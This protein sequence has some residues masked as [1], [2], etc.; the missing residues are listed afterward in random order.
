[1]NSVLVKL[2]FLGGPLFLAMLGA[3]TVHAQ[4][5]EVT[6]NSLLKLK[7][8]AALV[9]QLESNR[10]EERQTASATLA[11][12]GVAAIPVL[13]ERMLV[14]PPETAACC[15]R[16]LSR[17]AMNS[18]HQ[19]M[20][21]I[22]RVFMLLSKNGMQ[23]LGQESV[24][25]NA[26]WKQGRID[27]TVS[28]LSEVGINAEPV[29]Q[30]FAQAV[31]VF[32]EE[33]ITTETESEP[34][35]TNSKNETSPR[36]SPAPQKTDQ[37]ILQIV[38]QILESSQQENNDR[39]VE[40]MQNARVQK[41]Q[42]QNSTESS[43]RE[44]NP[45]A[46]LVESWDLETSENH[47]SVTIGPEFNGADED[48]KLLRLLPEIAQLTIVGQTIDSSML[49]L[50]TEDTTVQYVSLIEC[51]YNFNEIFELLQKR[52][53]MMVTSAGNQAF[54]GVQLQ[55]QINSEGKSVCQVLE[56]VADSA[57]EEAGIQALDVI[58]S[59]NGTPVAYLEQTI[60]AI[61]AFKP[62]DV[63]ALKIKRQDEDL[64]VNVTQ[65]E[66]AGER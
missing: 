43:F 46:F 25:L 52:P 34:K 35:S 15:G 19:D 22:A 60:L 17:I 26:R 41:S 33:F 40:E 55:T 9:E 11:E 7:E 24:Q 59:I 51:E 50:L 57:A 3:I 62:G 16:L 30:F 42:E 23:H 14:G 54:L 21:R 48:L 13:V 8:I 47:F 4:T 2:Y 28:Q 56:V 10:Y 37:E 49:D 18:E 12:Y 38:N 5:E 39:F 27:K 64:S 45:G 61:G 66:R 36:H 63:L 29:G 31:P 20:T 65:R 1:M 53:D 32:S 6:P 58:Q 44:S